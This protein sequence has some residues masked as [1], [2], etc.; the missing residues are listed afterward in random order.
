M[1]AIW[2]FLTILFGILLL[3]RHSVEETIRPLQSAACRGLIVILD[4]DLL[5]LCFIICFSFL[6]ATR[7]I[8]S[9]DA[10]VYRDWYF[11]IIDTP[12]FRY[13]GE[14]GF[15]FEYVVKILSLVFGSNY[16]LVF[17]ALPLINNLII[18]KVLRGTED[19]GT[20]GYLL[21]FCLNPAVLSI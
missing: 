14:Y 7:S 18:Y 9:Y 4:T 5:A 16:R 8:Y 3:V 20:S 21:Y 17:F 12:F 2:L 15:V 1:S 10:E 19:V 11:K 13:D 6:C